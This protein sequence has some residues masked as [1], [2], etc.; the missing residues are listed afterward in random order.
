LAG[1]ITENESNILIVFKTPKLLIF[2]YEAED[3]KLFVIKLQ[4]GTDIML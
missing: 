2:I 4:R 1:T 3:F